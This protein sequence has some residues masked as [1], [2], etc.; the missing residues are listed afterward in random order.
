MNYVEVVPADGGMPRRF[1]KAASLR[2][3][4][5]DLVRLVTGTG[6]G[7]GHPRERERGLVLEDLAN[8]LIDEREA[9]DVYG[10]SPDPD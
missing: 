6:G 7:H 2:L 5:G 9:R 3:A 4:R 10:V 8:G 1:G